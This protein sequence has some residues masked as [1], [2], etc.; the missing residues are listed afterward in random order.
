MSQNNSVE[1]LDINYD[2]LILNIIKLTVILTV[3][4][5][6]LN[7]VFDFGSAWALSVLLTGVL[8]ATVCMLLKGAATGKRYANGAKKRRTQWFPFWFSSND[9]LDDD[10]CKNHLN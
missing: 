8:A 5:A 4:L 1:R 9:N 3:S 7:S 2:G 6:I 10:A